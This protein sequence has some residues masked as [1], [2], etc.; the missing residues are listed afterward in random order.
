MYVRLLPV[1]SFRVVTLPIARLLRATRKRDVQV[2]VSFVG[3]GSIGK[4]RTPLFGH[5]VPD[6][7]IGSAPGC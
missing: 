4:G 7:A 6:G 1:M 3:V 2:V 5:Q